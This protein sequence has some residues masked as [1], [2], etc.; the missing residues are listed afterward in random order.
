MI[1]QNSGPSGHVC[2]GVFCRV[3]DAAGK[4]L[5]QS[6]VVFWGPPFRT[7]PCM[8]F[9]HIEA[10]KVELRKQLHKE[11]VAR[12]RGMEVKVVA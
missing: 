10:A 8:Q 2:V 11:K 12:L 4:S 1:L 6:E 5:P 9:R 3:L 7:H